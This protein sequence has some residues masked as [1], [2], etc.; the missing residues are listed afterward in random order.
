MGTLCWL[1]PRLNFVAD[2]TAACAGPVVAFVE[3]I[4]SSE[5]PLR[6]LRGTA[7]GTDGVVRVLAEGT[8]SHQRAIRVRP[9]RLECL[10][11]AAMDGR[12]HALVASVQDEAS[13]S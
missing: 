3:I 4:A 2:T 5:S 10:V 13:T 9:R 12:L 1:V 6:L 7:G 11:R 8:E